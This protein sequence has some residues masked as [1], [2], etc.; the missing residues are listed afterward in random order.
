V[1]EMG[2]ESGRWLVQHLKNEALANQ[3]EEVLEGEMKPYCINGHEY[4]EENR[5]YTKAGTIQCR[6][7]RRSRYEE[8]RDEKRMKWALE[9]IAGREEGRKRDL[10]RLRRLIEDSESKDALSIALERLESKGG[11]VGDGKVGV[12]E[13][14]RAR[15]PRAKSERDAKMAETF[16]R[17]EEKYGPKATTP[18]PEGG[19][20]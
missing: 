18:D 10:E 2:K 15:T 20:V 17:I 8:T 13:V 12:I 1:I 6:V 4:L 11:E 5:Y 9:T 16:K 3:T 19:M 14:K 7:C